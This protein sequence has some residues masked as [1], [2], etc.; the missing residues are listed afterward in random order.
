[1]TMLSDNWAEALEPGLRG[2]FTQAM[3]DYKNFPDYRKMI[4]TVENSQRALKSI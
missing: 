1:M 4:F 2:I 3:S